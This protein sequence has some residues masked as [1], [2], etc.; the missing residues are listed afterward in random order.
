MGCV[1]KGKWST[2]MKQ[3]EDPLKRLETPCNGSGSMDCDLDYFACRI[4]V[5]DLGNISIIWEAEPVHRG[6]AWRR[7]V[8]FKQAT[9][10]LMSSPLRL[11]VTADEREKL[12]AS[13]SLVLHRDFLISADPGLFSQ[14]PWTVTATD[15]IHLLAEVGIRTVVIESYAMKAAV[16][17]FLPTMNVAVPALSRAI[18]D[19]SRS[20]RPWPELN[21]R[22]PV[23]VLKVCDSAGVDQT[24]PVTLSDGVPT[25]VWRAEGDIPTLG[26]W[27]FYP[28]FGPLGLWRS[29]GYTIEMKVSH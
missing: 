19:I 27:S 29:G 18:V 8:F 21:N 9:C 23:F 15:L 4:S 10:Q 13:A 25:G 12:L 14:R 26:H 16:E 20:V 5:G 7:R 11:F 22:L 2:D 1:E 24:Y 28:M 17:R 6:S 3:S